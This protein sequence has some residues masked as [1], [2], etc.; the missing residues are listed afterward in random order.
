MIPAK[1]SDLNQTLNQLRA[2]LPLARIV[3]VTLPFL[4]TLDCQYLSLY[5]RC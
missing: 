5:T 2:N 4:I 1:H 3:E